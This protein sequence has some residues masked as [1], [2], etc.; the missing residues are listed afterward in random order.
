[1]P[2]DSVQTHPGAC[3]DVA[4]RMPLLAEHPRILPSAQCRAT[5]SVAESAP[6]SSSPSSPTNPLAPMSPLLRITRGIVSEEFAANSTGMQ[7]SFLGSSCT[8]PPGFRYV[9]EGGD[10]DGDI[11]SCCVLL[12]GAPSWCTCLKQASALHTL[13]SPSHIIIQHTPPHAHTAPLPVQRY[14]MHTRC[15]CL[16]LQRTH[17]ATCTTSHSWVIER[18]SVCLSHSDTLTTCWGCQVGVAFCHWVISCTCVNM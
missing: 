11:W 5:A 3:W 7:L 4:L 15:G 10:G 18:L 12:L 9:V 8:L 1:M 17:S 2:T 16:M 6:S 13:S 14:A